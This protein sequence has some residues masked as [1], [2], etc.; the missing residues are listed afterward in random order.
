[1]AL[2]WPADPVDIHQTTRRRSLRPTRA[3]SALLPE[4]GNVA[5]A[6][7]RD[8]RLFLHGPCLASRV[9]TCR[10]VTPVPRSAAREHRALIAPRAASTPPDAELEVS[11]DRVPV[12]EEAGL[13]DR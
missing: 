2:R 11:A 10:L 1:M 4:G 7:G 12:K 8:S 5:R 6:A 13:S 3:Q 9:E